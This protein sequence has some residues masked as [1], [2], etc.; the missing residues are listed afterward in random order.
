MGRGVAV[1]RHLAEGVAQDGT[2]SALPGNSPEARLE[3]KRRMLHTSLVTTPLK[4]KV[5]ASTTKGADLMRGH[6]ER[7]LS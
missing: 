4:L 3:E 1:K 7:E 5:A 6:F 2:R